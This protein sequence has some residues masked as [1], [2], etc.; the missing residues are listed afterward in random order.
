MLPALRWSNRTRREP[1]LFMMNM[2]YTTHLE[3]IMSPL[4]VDSILDV[5]LLLHHLS[6]FSR[7]DIQ[8]A[9]WMIIFID[10]RRWCTRPRKLKGEGYE[11][12]N[13]VNLL[14]SI[15]LVI[16]SLPSHMSSSHED[17]A[18][19]IDKWSFWWEMF[20]NPFLFLSSMIFKGSFIRVETMN[21]EIKVIV[22][23]VMASL[24]LSLFFLFLLLLL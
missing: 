18:L 2:T 1:T 15:S 16:V 11:D 4:W 24:F 10:I 20:S 13:L 7:G 5:L 12:G 17:K 6:Q 14:F 19:L 9:E 8:H 22:W 21:I 23:S 3:G